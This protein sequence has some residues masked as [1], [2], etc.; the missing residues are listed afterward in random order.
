MIGHDQKI[1]RP[2][3]ARA[4]TGR[5]GHFFAASE[6][7]GLLRSEEVAEGDG[8]E[9]LRRVQMRVAE[10]RTGREGI[11]G[12]GGVARLREKS[13]DRP[14]VERPLDPWFP[15]PARCS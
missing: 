11:A 8:V 4:L 2:A 13:L 5:G 14:R 7:I 3:Q 15:V 9:R 10:E 1:E 12:V 6:A